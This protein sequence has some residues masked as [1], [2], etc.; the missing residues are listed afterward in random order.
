MLLHRCFFRQAGWL[1]ERSRAASLSWP[2]KI[3][4]MYSTVRRSRTALPLYES[5]VRT[6]K[7]P[8]WNITDTK[9][10]RTIA[11]SRRFLLRLLAL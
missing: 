6:L 2:R 8:A 1:A 5:A 4:Q 10:R 7:A 9:R 3:G 11:N